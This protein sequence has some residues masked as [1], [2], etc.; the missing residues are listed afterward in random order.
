[1]RVPGTWDAFEIGVR[2]IIG[3]QVTVAG[4][5]T[6]AGRLVERHGSG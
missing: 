1:M 6:L 3:Q 2:A 5:S 4:A